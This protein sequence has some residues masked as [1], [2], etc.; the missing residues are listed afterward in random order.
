MTAAAKTE[1]VIYVVF[2]VHTHEVFFMGVQELARDYLF[3]KAQEA[4]DEGIPPHFAVLTETAFRIQ[5]PGAAKY[6]QEFQKENPHSTYV[7]YDLEDGEIFLI[8]NKKAAG[9]W[10]IQHENLHGYGIVDITEFRNKIID[11]EKKI[12]HYNRTDLEI[13]DMEEVLDTQRTETRRKV[14]MD[15]TPYL[16]NIHNM[17]EQTQVIF[18]YIRDYCQRLND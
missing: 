12:E 16:N 8:A 13:S 9:D 17:M 3:Y 1:K 15:L 18:A 11:A 2:M 6:I 7:I 4:T 14:G 10:L 5:I